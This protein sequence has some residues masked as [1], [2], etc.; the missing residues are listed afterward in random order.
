MLT[1]SYDLIYLITNAFNIPILYKFMGAFFE[2]PVSRKTVCALS[3]LSHFLITSIVY[4]YVDI[5][6]LNLFVNFAIFFVITLNYHSTIQRKLLISFYTLL[7]MSVIEIIVGSCTGY[8]HFSFFS[9]ANYAN[10]LGV[11]T[12]R[13]I[14]YM[15]A[16]LFKNFKMSRNNQKVTR[17]E[18]FASLFIPIT[19]LILEILIIHANNISQNEVLLSLVIVFLLNLLAFYLYDSLTKSYDKLSKVAVLEKENEL[20][21]KQCEIMQNS[22]EDLQSFR[23]DLNNQFIVITELLANGQYETAKAQISTLSQRTRSSVI[24]STTGN[25]V[26][27]G[28]INYKL[29]CAANENIAVNSEIAVPTDLE[30]ETTDIV[31]ILGNLLDNAIRALRELHP[32]ERSLSVKV[33]YSQG[34]LIIQ[35]INPYLTEV[36]YLNGELVSTQNDKHNHGFGIKNIET[37]VEKYDGYMEINHENSVFRVDI[38]LYLPR[39]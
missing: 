10:S 2:K 29:Q 32:D 31:T 16:L 25:T 22:T 11:I 12:A 3:Y 23:H 9:E 8:F 36:E 38:L 21:S 17:L 35:M 18:W 30:V 15:V 6:F 13:L 20:Y 4:L 19:T 7:F 37:V 1:D 33:V 24:Y 27:D 28:L 14:T 26:I 5:P 34:R 39:G